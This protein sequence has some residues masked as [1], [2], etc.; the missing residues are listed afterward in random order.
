MKGNPSED[1]IASGDSAA[2]MLG[3]VKIEDRSFMLSDALSKRR[4]LTYEKIK[5]PE[6][7]L[8][9]RNGMAQKKP[10]A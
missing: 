2:S 7:E 3:M 10:I 4:I 1:E 8:P 5:E 6:I 9:R